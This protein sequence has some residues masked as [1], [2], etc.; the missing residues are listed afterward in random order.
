MSEFRQVGQI[1]RLTPSLALIALGV[2]LTWL[3]YGDW[4]N[5]AT[6]FFVKVPGPIGMLGVGA[7]TLRKTLLYGKDSDRMTGAIVGAALLIAVAIVIA[8]AI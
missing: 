8:G 5:P 6:M 1:Y 7:W 4:S 2:G 3:F